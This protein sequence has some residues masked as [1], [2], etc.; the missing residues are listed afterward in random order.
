MMSFQT[1]LK[2]QLIPQ[3]YSSKHIIQSHID[4]FTVDVNEKPF[5]GGDLLIIVLL[6][7]DLTKTLNPP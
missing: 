4:S 3:M 5:F 1:D 2:Q 7:S 6:I